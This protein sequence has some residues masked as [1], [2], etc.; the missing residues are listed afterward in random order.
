MAGPSLR[1]LFADADERTRGHCRDLF[2]MLGHRVT[3]V[4]EG[5]AA[6][7]LLREAEFDIVF[8]H[9]DLAG[10]SGVDVLERAFEVQPASLRILLGD[11]MDPRTLTEAEQRGRAHAFVEKPSDMGTLVGSARSVPISAGPDSGEQE[12]ARG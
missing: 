1:I 4:G 5:R 3:L 2:L 10:A 11:A 9:A 6:L 7:A 8:A 12:S